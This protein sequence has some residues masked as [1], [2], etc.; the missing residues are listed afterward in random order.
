MK[1]SPLAYAARGV[2]SGK[3]SRFLRVQPNDVWK[4]PVPCVA[5]SP[6]IG[7]P[8]LGL[9][10]QCLPAAQDEFILAGVPLRRCDEI[11]AAVLVLFR[12]TRSQTDASISSPPQGP[13]MALSNTPDGISGYGRETP[14]TGCRRSHEA[15]CRKAGFPGDGGWPACRALHGAPVVGVE[16][17]RA[18]LGRNA[19][20]QTG[21]WISTEA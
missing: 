16:D 7:M 3:T 20:F 13:Q 5:F 17:Q 8:G 9:G 19:V 15:G 11:E 12:C 4:R 1:L 21:L 18:L 6:S 10:H 14:S 2:G